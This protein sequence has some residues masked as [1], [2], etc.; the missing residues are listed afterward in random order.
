MGESAGRFAVRLG[1]R[2]QS[3]ARPYFPPPPEGMMASTTE[4]DLWA[5]A[6]LFPLAMTRFWLS[7]WSFGLKLRSHTA[8]APS[9]GVFCPLS[10]AGRNPRRTTRNFATRAMNLLSTTSACFFSRSMKEAMSAVVPE[11]SRNA[12]LDEGF[13]GRARQVR[14]PD[15]RNVSA[16]QDALR[17]ETRYRE[18]VLVARFVGYPAR[19]GQPDALAR[20]TGGPLRS[21]RRS[22]DRRR[23]VRA[24]QLLDEVEGVTDAGGG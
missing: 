7:V 24:A 2:A 8:E 16:E 1:S 17:M 23:R 5:D 9:R 4:L 3:V 22:R 11:I 20:G 14:G 6:V 15:H 21:R 18:D 19:G 13:V 12:S 10:M